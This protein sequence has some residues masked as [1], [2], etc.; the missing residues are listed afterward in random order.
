MI[1]H[2]DKLPD[3]IDLYHII[4]SKRIT[5]KIY[6]TCMYSPKDGAVLHALHVLEPRHFWL[7]RGN[8]RYGDLI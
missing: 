4:S 6:N 7:H 3:R 8:H 1:S 5:C 2:G